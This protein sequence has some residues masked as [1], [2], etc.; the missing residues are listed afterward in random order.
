M[1][2]DSAKEVELQAIRKKLVSVKYLTFIL[3]PPECVLAADSDG[4]AR[5]LSHQAL[6]GLGS[7]VAAEVKGS[8]RDW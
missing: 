4:A 2:E 8:V 5:C 6:A 3:G 1:D 7:K